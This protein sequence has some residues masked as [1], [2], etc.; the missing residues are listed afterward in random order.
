[1]PKLSDVRLS[2]GLWRR[3][4]RSPALYLCLDV[5]CCFGRVSGGQDWSADHDV[6]G[7]GLGGFCRGHHPF[8]VAEAGAGRPDAWDDQQEIR[9][10]CLPQGSNFMG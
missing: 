9:A 5:L 6:L 8:L 10:E 2:S 3:S 1:M 7:S 4:V